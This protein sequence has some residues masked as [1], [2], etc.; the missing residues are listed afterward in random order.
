M[1]T[2]QVGHTTLEIPDK[3]PIP[4]V[5]GTDIP[6]ITGDASVCGMPDVYGNIAY[7]NRICLANKPIGSGGNGSGSNGDCCSTFSSINCVTSTQIWGP[8]SDGSFY[9]TVTNEWG[10]P[11]LGEWE[12]S[13]TDTIEW[14]GGVWHIPSDGK[15][16]IGYGIYLHLERPP[17]QPFTAPFEIEHGLTWNEYLE[18]I[19]QFDLVHPRRVDPWKKTG[20]YCLLGSYLVDCWEGMTVGMYARL[21]GNIGDTYITGGETGVLFYG[22]DVLDGSW[23]NIAKVGSYPVEVPLKMHGTK[24]YHLHPRVEAKK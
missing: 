18:W 17:T 8:D 7:F 12:A 14:S 16:V 21:I 19:Y 20:D 24:E 13:P 4:R 3:K 6:N 1:T 5:G 10:W 15:Y 9:D 22:S 23:A 2:L 11:H